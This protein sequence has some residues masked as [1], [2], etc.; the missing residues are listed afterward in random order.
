MSV[1]GSYEQIEEFRK[2]AASGLRQMITPEVLRSAEVMRDFCRHLL[3]ISV[4]LPV[5]TDFDIAD[6]SAEDLVL[7]MADAD[8]ASSPEGMVRALELV[9][10]RDLCEM[11]L[12]HQKGSNR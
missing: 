9:T 6:I 1:F 3:R 8:P 2:R 5:G 10:T 12:R 4:L 7:G 11:V